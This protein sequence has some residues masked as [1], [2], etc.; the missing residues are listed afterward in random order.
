MRQTDLT[1][2]MNSN[3]MIKH[4]CNSNIRWCLKLSRIVNENDRLVDRWQVLSFN[5]MISRRLLKRCNLVRNYDQFCATLITL[6]YHDCV[7]ANLKEFVQLLRKLKR[8]VIVSN[9]FWLC[10]QRHFALIKIWLTAI[11]AASKDKLRNR[12]YACMKLVWCI[13]NLQVKL[14]PNVLGMIEDSEHSS[15]N[16]ANWKEVVCKSLIAPRT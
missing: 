3:I 14:K 16:I 12:R 9:R 2:I 15:F 1:A 6:G 11:V 8:C 13:E 7:Y 10:K 4:L 5:R